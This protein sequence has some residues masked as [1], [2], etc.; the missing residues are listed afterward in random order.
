MDIKR[1]RESVLAANL[2]LVTKKL[3]ISTWGNVSGYDPESKLVV[4]KA[5]GVEYQDMAVEHMTVLD[6]DGNIVEGKCRPSTDTITHLMIYRAFGDEGVCGVVH[7]HSQ[8]ATIWAQS[9][10]SL[11][12]YGTTH[13]DYF[14]GDVPTT[15]LMTDEEINGEYEKN[16]GN[17]ILESMSGRNCH[18][19][20]AV[21]V[22]S[23]GPFVWG[24][25]P[26]EAVLHAQ[27][28]EYSAKMA[29]CNFVMSSGSC[30]PIQKVLGDKHYNR[31]F[32]PNSYYGQAK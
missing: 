19:T 30:P 24:K 31:K 5:S 26:S 4:I 14:Y 16:T 10:M 32:G 29:W 9:G 23:H 2:D 21:L 12:C 15:R 3:V 28:L 25:S 11:P 1:L 27:V 7:T 17:V 13:A 18:S 8:F 6:L 20:S 22:H